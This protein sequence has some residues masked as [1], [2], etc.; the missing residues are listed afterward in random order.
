MV[1][2]SSVTASSALLHRH[3]NRRSLLRA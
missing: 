1:L 2:K 3:S